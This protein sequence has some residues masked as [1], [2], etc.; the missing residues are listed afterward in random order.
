MGKRILILCEAIAPP[1]Y[2]PRIITMVHYLRTRGWHCE[3][4]TEMND[5]IPFLSNACKIHQMPTYR[6][7]VADKLLGWKEKKLARYCIDHVDVSSFDLILCASYYYFPLQAAY[8]LAK[9]FNRPLVVD[10]RDIAEQWGSLDYYTRSLTG[11]DWIDN[12][13]KRLYTRINMRQRN[14]VLRYAKAVTTVSV[15]HRDMLSAYNANTRLIYNGYD[16]HIFSPLAVKSTTFDI[17][18]IGKYYAHYQHC[19][20]FLMEAVRQLVAE[21]KVSKKDVRIKFYTNKLGQKSFAQLATTYGVAKLVSVYDY[22]PRDQVVATMHK[23]SILMVMTLSHH[24]YNTHGMMGTKFYEIL[25]I[26]K[27]CLCLNSDEECLA[28]AISD[29]HAGL[30]ATNVEEVKAFVLEKYQEWKANGFTHQ[31]VVNKEQFTRQRQTEQFEELF[32]EC[33]Q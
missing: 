22:I 14:R 12:I 1:A 21:G 11:I 18:F 31:E 9:R 29:T 33:I 25:G 23:S 13:A 24:K 17:S 8:R 10:L 15:W 7:L 6:N 20:Q 28:Q 32:V 27:P 26:E 2:S 3:I 16:Q 19:P 30:A 5:D 4:V